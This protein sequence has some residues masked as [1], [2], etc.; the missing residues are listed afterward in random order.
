ME[1]GDKLTVPL[2]LMG[3]TRP[4]GEDDWEGGSAA[5]SPTDFSDILTLDAKFP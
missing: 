2:R 4:L 5:P 3:G 1:I